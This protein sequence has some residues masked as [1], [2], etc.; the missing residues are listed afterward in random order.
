M[1][2]KRKVTLSVE[3]PV[4]FNLGFT[5]FVL[6]DW[7]KTRTPKGVRSLN[8][9]GCGVWVVGAYMPLINH[10]EKGLGLQG[11]PLANLWHME[12]LLLQDRTKSLWEIVWAYCSTSPFFLVGNCTNL[13]GRQFCQAA[14][15]VV[16]R[17][18]SQDAEQKKS[19]V[20]FLLCLFGIHSS[21]KNTLLMIAFVDCMMWVWGYEPH[22]HLSFII[23]KN[24]WSYCTTTGFLMME[25]TLSTKRG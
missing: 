8:P 22:S 24:C 11:T 20:G 9:Q 4:L 12:K 10:I 21:R 2:I 5:C 13:T 25:T 16:W 18:Y 19:L 7:Q 14:T 1:E 3:R 17:E 6:L 23:A 15:A